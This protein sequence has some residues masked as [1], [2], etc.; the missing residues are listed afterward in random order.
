M[1]IYDYRCED[2]EHEFELRET[3]SEHESAKHECPKCGGARLR[4][5]FAGAFVQTSRKS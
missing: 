1:P 4:R 2:C 3:M 5:V